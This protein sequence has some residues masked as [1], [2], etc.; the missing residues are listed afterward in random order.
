[1]PAVLKTLS[2]LTIHKNIVTRTTVYLWRREKYVFKDR[3][4]QY[5]RRWCAQVYASTYAIAMHRR[6]NENESS[7]EILQL[8]T[9]HQNISLQPLPAAVF[10]LMLNS[11]PPQFPSCNREKNFNFVCASLAR[12]TWRINLL[13]DLASFLQSLRWLD[14]EYWNILLSHLGLKLIRL[15]SFENNIVLYTSW[16]VTYFV[17]TFNVFKYGY[18]LWSMK[19]R[20]V[21]TLKFL[22]FQANVEKN[23]V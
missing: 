12:L 8:T 19:Q 5:Y 6:P 22:L 18:F 14:A 10:T 15:R 23:I 11:R 21:F 16:N 20:A 13:H 1:M 3:R 7:N 2:D 17:E 9:G 4:R